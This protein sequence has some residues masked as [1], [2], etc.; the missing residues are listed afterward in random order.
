MCARH[1]ATV[2]KPL[3][4]RVYEAWDARRTAYQEARRGEITWADYDS[5]AAAHQEVR[6]EAIR[7]AAEQEGGG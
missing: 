1:W 7:V 5:V 6:D 3:Q 2:P 4:A